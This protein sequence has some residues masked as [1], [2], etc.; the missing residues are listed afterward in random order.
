[1]IST[2][3]YSFGD[4]FLAPPSFFHI[5]LL[6]VASQGGH[7]SVQLKLRFF[8]RWNASCFEGRQYQ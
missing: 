2:Q 5:T 7:S 1:M 3:L 4:E 8:N 6:N